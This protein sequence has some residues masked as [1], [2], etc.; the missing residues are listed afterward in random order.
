MSTTSNGNGKK[1]KT[2][3]EIAVI[4]F[5]IFIAIAMMVPS[6]GYI[7]SYYKYQHQPQAAQ[8]E[9]NLTPE[10][11]NQSFADIIKQYNELIEKEQRMPLF[12]LS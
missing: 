4:V 5:S 3:K 10:Q 12:M 9:Q 7:V 6:I 2:G 11:I 8:Q 1:K